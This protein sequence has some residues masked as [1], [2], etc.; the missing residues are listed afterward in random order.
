MKSENRKLTNSQ[1]ETTAR[2]LSDDELER[3][4]GGVIISPRRTAVPTDPT[5]GDPGP[6][7]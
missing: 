6:D 2:R 1:D 4:T 7:L 3:V 5:P